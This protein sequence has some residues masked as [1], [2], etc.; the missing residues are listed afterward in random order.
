M[1]KLPAKCPSCDQSLLVSE[2]ACLSCN[3]KISGSFKLPILSN[4]HQEDQD[5]ILEFVRSSGSLKKMAVKFGVS[6]PTVR[7]R[8]DDLIEIIKKVDTQI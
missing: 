4:L 8:L 3:T 5:F 6:Y 1:N 2:L 7:N